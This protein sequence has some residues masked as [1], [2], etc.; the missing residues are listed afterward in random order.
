VS[1]L[2]AVLSLPRLR[3]L[4]RLHRHLRLAGFPAA[5]L[6]VFLPSAALSLATT[7][8]TISALATTPSTISAL[9]TTPSTISAL[10]SSAATHQL[11]GTS[12]RVIGL[13]NHS[14]LTHVMGWDTCHGMGEEGTAWSKVLKETDVLSPDHCGGKRQK[15]GVRA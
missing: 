10:A 13:L 1:A 9:A 7:P 14:I 5:I 15:G 12:A 8:S 4:Q 11:H 6:A 3:Q 2:L